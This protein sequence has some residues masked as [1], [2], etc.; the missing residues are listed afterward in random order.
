MN[1]KF[2]IALALS[3]VAI[4]ATSV[5]AP[6]IA[7][8]KT[9][10][11]AANFTLTNAYGKRVS[12]NQ[13]RGKTV[14]LEWHN[15]GCPFVQKHYN[16]G[17]MQRTQAAARAQGVVWLT[18]NSG[19]KGKQGYISGKQAAAMKKAQKAKFS[20]YLFDRSGVVGKLYSA[21]TTPHMYIINAKG[22]LV[23]QG[24]IDS[25]G[26]AN[27]ADIEKAR[28]HVTSALDEMAAGKAVS[29]KRSR[30]YGCSVKYATS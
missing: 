29:V 25:I 26:S 10:Q 9:G 3:A 7:A 22:V 18:I 2:A 16:S 15:P 23:Y 24:G 12:L 20:H 21:R 19:A 11:T 28:N 1:R 6:I 13:F 17:N 5:S 4:T 30:P 14:V 27:I 8:Q